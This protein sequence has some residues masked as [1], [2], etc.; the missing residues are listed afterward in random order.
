MLENSI[1]QQL[2]NNDFK[3]YLNV[4]IVRDLDYIIK[5]FN[6]KKS[7]YVTSDTK[8]PGN[9][10]N[11]LY[12]F[13]MKNLKKYKDKENR[14]GMLFSIMLPNGFHNDINKQ[15]QLTEKFVSMVRQN[16]ITLKY[17]SWSLNRGKGQ[18]LYI[19]ISDRYYVDELIPKK[20]KSTRYKDSL[21]GNWCKETDLNAVISCKK[22]EICK[23][24]DGE[25]IYESCFKTKTRRFIVK[26]EYDSNGI[27]IAWKRFLRSFRYFLRESFKQLG[28]NFIP[29]RFFKKIYCSYGLNRFKKRIVIAINKT[30]GFLE[31]EINLLLNYEFKAPNII[32]Q[33]KYHDDPNELFKTKR[34][35]QID[36]LFHKYNARFQKGSFHKDGKLYEIKNTRCDYAEK[37]VEIMKDLFLQ[38]IKELY[39]DNQNV[40]TALEKRWNYYK[41]NFENENNVSVKKDHY[42]ELEISISDLED[43]SNKAYKLHELYIPKSLVI[44]NE[45]NHIISIPYWFYKRNQSELDALT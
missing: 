3:H 37:N 19:Y 36:N 42:I 45:S 15:K 17:V 26:P 8:L 25:V 35:K 9:F 41:C 12:E 33:Y 22:G 39:K 14:F 29:G 40:I 38:E 31:Q 27:D 20:H 11:Q 10:L 32:D 28:I 13:E 2:D 16:D 23:N 1:I 44:L 4:K 18:Y 5:Q 6:R 24:K 30:M 34:G 7:I 43:Y 21:T